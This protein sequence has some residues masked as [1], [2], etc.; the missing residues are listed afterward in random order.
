MGWRVCC[1]RHYLFEMDSFENWITT[2][3]KKIR[4]GIGRLY[5][6]KTYEPIKNEFT[7]ITFHDG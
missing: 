6:V 7:N 2:A 3:V 1:R 5:A 4:N